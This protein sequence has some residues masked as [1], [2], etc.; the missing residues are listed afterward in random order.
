MKPEQP[1]AEPIRLSTGAIVDGRYFAAGSVLPFTKEADV[2]ENLRPYIAT[3]EEILPP[4][5]RNIYDLPPHLRRQAR[6]IQANVQWQDWAEAQASEPL[7]PDVAEVLQDSHDKY[8]SIKAQMAY[9]QDASD[10][11]YASA[12][13]REPQKFFVKRGA[14]YA[15]ARKA[16]KLKVAENV[17]ALRP[18]G[19]YECIG[20]V[21][22]EGQL[23]PE[24]IIT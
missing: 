22:S 7:P 3:E 8:I 21:D 11:A 4:P 23:P 17:Y 19:E 12:A 14:V 10:N 9:N 16:S 13:P 1:P 18:N 15:D 20:I 24:E 5:V 2:P 6:Q